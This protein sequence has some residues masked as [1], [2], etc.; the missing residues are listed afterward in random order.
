LD[1]IV[2]PLIIPDGTLKGFPVTIATFYTD[3]SAVMVTYFPVN[4]YCIT[5]NSRY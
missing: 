2:P 4:R 1:I 5:I 3:I